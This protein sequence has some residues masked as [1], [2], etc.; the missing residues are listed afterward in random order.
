[1]VIKRSEAFKIHCVLGLVN[2]MPRVIYEIWSD[3]FTIFLCLR[4]SPCNENLQ[5]HAKTERNSG[6]DSV[7]TTTSPFL[8]GKI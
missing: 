5:H 6:K 8:A 7:V 1:M 3:S 2:V 4:R